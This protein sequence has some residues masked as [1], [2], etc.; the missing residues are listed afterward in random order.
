MLRHTYATRSVAGGMD[1]A[2][3][4]ALMG[5]TDIGVTQRYLHPSLDDL[6]NAVTDIE[7][8]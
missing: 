7:G 2:R 4:K 8:M 5:H 3:L 1:L 6:N